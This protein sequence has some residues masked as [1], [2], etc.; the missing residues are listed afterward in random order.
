MAELLH[1]LH[2]RKPLPVWDAKAAAALVADAKRQAAHT[3]FDELIA[4][5]EAARALAAQIHGAGT[6]EESESL[7]LQIDDALDFARKHC[8]EIVAE[9]I[10]AEEQWFADN[11]EFF[12]EQARGY[13]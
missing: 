10:T 4:H 3:P 6:H 8:L 9:E 11:E 7:H 12:M 13:A 2:E 1:A 5:L